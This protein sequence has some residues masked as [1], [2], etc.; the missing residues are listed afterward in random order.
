MYYK[1]HYNSPVGKIWLV[2]DETNLVGA[3]LQGQKYF[4]GTLTQELMLSKEV[5]V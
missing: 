4:F 1:T 5:P 2:S 3:W